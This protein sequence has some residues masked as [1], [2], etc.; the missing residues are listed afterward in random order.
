LP[1]AIGLAHCYHPPDATL[2]VTLLEGAGGALVQVGAL[3][4]VEW[5]IE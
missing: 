3:F 2:K 5:C 1:D 4:Q